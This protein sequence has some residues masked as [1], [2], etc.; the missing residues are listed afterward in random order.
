LISIISSVKSR[1]VNSMRL[2]IPIFIQNPCEE[3]G[4]QLSGRVFT[5]VLSLPQHTYTHEIFNEIQSVQSVV[6]ML[7]N[8]SYSGGKDWLSLV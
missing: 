2:R 3:L 5:R 8:P 6:V 4:M 7:I 1:R